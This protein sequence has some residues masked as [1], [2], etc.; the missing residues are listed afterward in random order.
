[1]AEQ[2]EGGQTLDLPHRL[3]VLVLSPKGKQFQLSSNTPDL[4]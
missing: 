4:I 2:N 3:F 1:M